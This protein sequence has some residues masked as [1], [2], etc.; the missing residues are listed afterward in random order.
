[1]EDSF[2]LK[3][4]KITEVKVRYSTQIGELEAQ[5]GFFA[6]IIKQ[7]KINMSQE[8]EEI[9]RKIDENRKFLINEA[10]RELGLVHN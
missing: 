4:E 2:S 5:G 7:M 6:E 9:S 1:M 3:T 8:I 10:K